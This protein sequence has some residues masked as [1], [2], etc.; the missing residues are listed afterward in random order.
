MATTIQ[1]ISKGFEEIECCDAVVEL[2]AQQA[3][4]ICARAN[5]NNTRGGQGFTVVNK[6]GFAFKTRRAISLVNTTDNESRIAESEDK[7]LSRAVIG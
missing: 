1:F 5:A 2:V 3:E 7:A 4:E 6:M